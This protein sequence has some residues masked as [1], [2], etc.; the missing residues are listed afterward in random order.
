MRECPEDSGIRRM[1]SFTRTRRRELL[2]LL[3]VTLLLGTLVG[4]VGPT[5]AADA[6]ARTG[7]GHAAS[8]R[9]AS[10]AGSQIE[11]EQTT[12]GNVFLANET[13]ELT[14]EADGERVAWTVLDHDGMAVAEGTTLVDGEHTL[15]LP[16]DRVGH[17][18]LRVRPD[19]APA[20]TAR[21]TLAVLPADGFDNDDDFF[22]MSTKFGAGRDHELMD[23]LELLGVAAVRDEH[24]W[25]GVEQSRGE[26]DFSGA[27]RA[28]F[29][30]TLRERGFDRLFL[31]VYANE[32]YAEDWEGIFTFP[33][34][35]EARSG[36]ANYTRAVLEEYPDLEHVEVWNEPNIEGFSVGPA[37]QDPGAYVRLL[38]A[39]YDAV[40]ETRPNVT[41]V[42]GSATAEYGTDFQLVDEAWW[43]GVFDAGGA[44]SMDAIAVH[45]YRGEPVGFDASAERL[46]ELTRAGND[47][48]ALPI[49]IT[50]LGWP[51][52][53][54]YAGGDHET[55]QAQ[56]AV[57]SHVRLRAAGVERYYWYTQ[58]D[59]YY[60]D[61]RWQHADGS[62][63]LGLL[64][65]AD[66]PL[67]RN[68]PK[69]AF[70][71]YATMTRQLA[72]ATFV[73]NASSP[74]ERYSF[75]DG[76]DSIHVLWA[77]DGTDLTVETRQPITVTTMTGREQT[78]TPVDEEVYL[79]VGRDP[80]Y[81][82]GSVE[83]LQ[84]GAPVGIDASISG[85][86]AT[87][88]LTVSLDGAEGPDSVT[89]E[90][91]GATAT[92]SADD[93]EGASDTLDVPDAYGDRAAVAVDTVSVDRQP[94]G[95]LE[96]PV[97]VPRAQ[98]TDPPAITGMTVETANEGRSNG[99]SEANDV[100]TSDSPFTATSRAGVACWESDVGAGSTGRRLYVDLQNSH[101]DWDGAVPVTVR[102]FDDGEGTFGLEYQDGSG[103][104]GAT[105]PVEL[106]GDGAWET[107]TF[108]LDDAAFG[109]A[110]HR[111]NHETGHDLQFTLEGSLIGQSEDDVCV[112]SLTMGTEAATTI[113][114]TPTDG[115]GSSGGEATG[116][117][118]TGGQTTDGEQ[119]GAGESS[120]GGEPSGPS[121]DATNAGTAS[122]DAGDGSGADD[123]SG[124]R[125]FG[126]VAAVLAV[127]T[128]GGLLARRQE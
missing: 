21:T 66:N 35:D 108:E 52:S 13:P 80:V 18:T 10:A 120:T 54:H 31:L 96:T 70:P 39:S 113:D 9:Q 104:G 116:G 42:G 122:G 119:T 53:P 114:P 27:N 64:R 23:T 26:Y 94:V 124:L 41:V 48:E 98:F 103:H 46:R 8:E 102:Y 110:E 16:I 50:E 117:S 109:P 86:Q 40:Q 19:D 97:G 2:L 81:L 57:Q 84:R 67:G 111:I 118:S 100:G 60:D 92:V 15:T 37:G 76:G 58:V 22:A 59:T 61:S 43:E 65:G 90:I 101:D 123:G 73:E 62:D 20:T 36:Y 79:T 83:G 128:A 45:L 127:L 75:E 72:G 105:V 44:Q 112:E 56:H 4:A 95:R 17:Y 125:G 32:L 7:I 30:E 87:D 28:G 71:A 88:R 115:G 11:I 121:D 93:G 78:L 5:A 106:D 89:H 47:G 14:L 1:L 33:H 107:H 55:R 34:T 29:M 68:A 91:A 49:W 24:G 77:D 63:Q 82:G 12:R 74:V 126:P 3:G 85:G 51:T 69:P 38:E 6:D 25:H 99:F